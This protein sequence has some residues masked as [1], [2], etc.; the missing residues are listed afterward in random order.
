[1]ILKPSLCFRVVSVAL[2][3]EQRVGKLRHGSSKL[4]VIVNSETLD[5]ENPYY[6]LDLISPLRVTV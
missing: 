3:S 4:D 5:L 1:M 2:L 6:L